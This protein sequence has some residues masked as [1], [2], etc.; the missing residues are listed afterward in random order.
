MLEKMGIRSFIEIAF[1]LI[2]KKMFWRKRENHESWGKCL[3]VFTDEIDIIW[4]LAKN[5]TDKKGKKV[6]VSRGKKQGKP[7]F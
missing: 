4:T 6:K 3:G 1:L 7:N 5:R 2:L